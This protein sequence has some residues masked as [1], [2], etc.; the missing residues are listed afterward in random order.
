M[1][2]M[3]FDLISE[4]SFTKPA[5]KLSMD[6]KVTLVQS[7]ALHQ[8]ILSTLGEFS[9]LCDGLDTLRAANAMEQYGVLLQQFFC[10]QEVQLVCYSYFVCVCKCGVLYANRQY[11]QNFQDRFSE[12]DSNAH[13]KEQDTHMMQAKI[14]E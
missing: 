1:I 3:S 10:Q 4:C 8:L 14:W 7:V 13:E 12:E 9:R 2:P 6:D 11:L 5:T